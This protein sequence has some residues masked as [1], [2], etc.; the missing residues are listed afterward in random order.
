M[1][2]R[3]RATTPSAPSTACRPPPC[4]VTASSASKPVA[5]AHTPP[6]TIS[7][8]PALRHCCTS[9][10]SA[11]RLSVASLRRSPPEER[12]PRS[13]LSTVSA[14]PP[15]GLSLMVCARMAALSLLPSAR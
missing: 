12:E 4:A 1:L 11:A 10:T 3:A 9:P 13:H 6:R 14:F 8:K 5:V 15:P 2:I 7:A